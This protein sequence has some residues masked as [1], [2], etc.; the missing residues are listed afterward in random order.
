M[1]KRKKKRIRFSLESKKIIAA[2]QGQIGRYGVII[3]KNCGRVFPLDI[4]EV[5]HIKPIS[6]GGTDEPS[7]LIL[8]C[9]SCNRRLGARKGRK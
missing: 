5:H 6:K 1:T 8:L 2:Y 3:C 9:P 7:N 4:M